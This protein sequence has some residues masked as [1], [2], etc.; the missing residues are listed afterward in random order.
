[1]ATESDL[2]PSYNTL[3]PEDDANI[4]INGRRRYT[5]ITLREINYPGGC[6]CHPKEVKG[7]KKAK[8]AT[9][10]PPPLHFSD[11]NESLWLGHARPMVT[12]RSQSRS[13]EISNSSSA[14]TTS[15]TSISDDSRSSRARPW[16]WFSRRTSS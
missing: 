10:Q 9:Q 6:P 15:N 4:T 7:K 13:T 16:D 3:F 12:E 8:K 14:S 5:T 2:L 11:V 1:M